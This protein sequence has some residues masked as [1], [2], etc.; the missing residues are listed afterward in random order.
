M[1]PPRFLARQKRKLKLDLGP[2][3]PA[4]T[5]DVSP[6]GFAVECAVVQ[7]P[8]TRLRGSLTVDQREFVFTGEVSWAQMGDPRMS[9]R[10]RMGIR[11]VEIDPAFYTLL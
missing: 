10:G 9:L 1:A 6:G 5:S 8:G 3:F 4:F 2:S 11:F 7:R